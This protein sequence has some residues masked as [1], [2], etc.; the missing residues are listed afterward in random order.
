VKIGGGM[1]EPGSLYITEGCTIP[2]RWLPVKR[3]NPCAETPSKQL[4][5]NIVPSG[6]HLITVFIAMLSVDG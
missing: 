1:P 3:G 5:A 6:F 2:P 4:T